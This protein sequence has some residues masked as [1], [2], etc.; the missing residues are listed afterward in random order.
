[1]ARH[2]KKAAGR[3]ASLVFTDESGFLLL[4]LVRRTLAPR[5][6]AAP[7]LHR[8]RHRDKV[9]V[10]AA[11]TLSP[12]RGHVSLHY[13]TYPNGYVNVG[14]YAQFL[15]TVLRR[16]RSPVRLMRTLARLGFAVPA[17]R[18]SAP[19]AG[20][21]QRRWLIK[22]RRSGGGRGV[23]A[24]RGGPVGRAAYLQERIAGVAGSIVFLADGRRAW[25]LGLTRQ[26]VG[27]AV[28]GAHGFAYCG[29]LLGPG[30]FHRE[31]EL[32]ARAAAL[33]DTVVAEYGLLGLNGIDFIARDG[34][35]YPIEV[36]PRPCASMELVERLGG[37]LLFPLH[38]RAC[39]GALPGGSSLPVPGRVVG[40]AVV[41]ARRAVT[42]GDLRSTPGIADVPHPG[43]TIGRSH[44]ICTIFTDGKD[45]DACLQAL[46]SRARAI[47]AAV[48]PRARGAA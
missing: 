16:V 37:P 30:L 41:F 36:N 29:S 5:G 22:R 35:P 25:P 10:A 48:E 28:F 43:E 11:L 9:S 4:P 31:A 39:R 7:L 24:Y 27:E 21:V 45:A 12:A 8:A 1:V 26:L 2:Q 40:K 19:G 14:P 23:A 46:G 15:R 32:G 34:V 38:Q 3:R 42:V 47:Y 17:T 33:A 13:Q 44:P 18:T 20:D 6:H